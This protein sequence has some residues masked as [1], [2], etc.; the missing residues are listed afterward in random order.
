MTVTSKKKV[1]Y[2]CVFQ[3]D[4]AERQSSESFCTSCV[5]DVANLVRVSRT[6]VYAIKKRMD[7]CE[8]VNRRASRD[9]KTVVNRDSLRDAIQSSPRTSIRQRSRRLGD[10]AALCDE[11]LLNLEQSPVSLWKDDC[12]RLLCSPSAFELRD[13]SR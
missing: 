6:T 11:L 1:Y 7:V 3:K 10:R 13:G 5:G 12:S 4:S 2:C 9:R 8:G